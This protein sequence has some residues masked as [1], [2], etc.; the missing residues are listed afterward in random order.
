MTS[1]ELAKSYLIK[2]EKRFKILKIL[3]KEE[4][5]S[6]VIRESQ[7]IVELCLKGILRSVGIEPPKFHDVS[8]L[9]E[10]YKERF[11][12]L[13]SNKIKKIVKI[14][15]WLRKEREIAFYGE[16]DFIPTEEYTSEDAKKAISGAE[17]ILEIAKQEISKK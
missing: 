16:V 9:I 13:T 5:Y 14:S 4:D 15:K 7:K 6:D 11:P 12:H 1:I 8:F 2:A 17:F 10:E 3:F